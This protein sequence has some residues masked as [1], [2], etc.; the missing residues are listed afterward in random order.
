MKFTPILHNVIGNILKV[1]EV[2]TLNSYSYEANYNP[3]ALGL[4][5]ILRFELFNYVF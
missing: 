1:S 4:P 2:K 3:A 5:E